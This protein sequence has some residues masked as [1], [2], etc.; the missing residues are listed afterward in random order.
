MAERLGLG[1]TVMGTEGHHNHRHALV[2]TA[3]CPRC[4]ELNRLPKTPKVQTAEEEVVVQP[5]P[6]PS[7]T[8]M[9][10]SG[11]VAVEEGTPPVGFFAR[12]EAERK[13][14]LAALKQN[15][16][17]WSDGW[18]PSITVEPTMPIIMEAGSDQT[19]VQVEGEGEV[20]FCWLCQGP[21]ELLDCPHRIQ[22]ER[23]GGMAAA[24]IRSERERVR[25]RVRQNQERATLPTES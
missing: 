7:S 22:A 20:P 23:G 8:T 12:A 11:F 4:E 6:Q 5:Q 24:V 21:H 18:K 17:T 2:R 3:G 25:V 19:S 9:I 14:R 1:I 16:H 10:D 15:G 13:E